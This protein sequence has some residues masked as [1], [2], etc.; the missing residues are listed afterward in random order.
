M[1]TATEVS[2][3]DRIKF[4][5]HRAK[6]CMPKV[7]DTDHPTPYDLMHVEINRLLDERDD[8][9]RTAQDA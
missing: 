8:G 4:A 5:C 9:E 3:E 1:T 2:I 6:R 7:G